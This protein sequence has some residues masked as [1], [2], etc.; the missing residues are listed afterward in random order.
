MCLCECHF[1]LLHLAFGFLLFHVEDTSLWIV[2]LSFVKIY[3]P[4]VFWNSRWHSQL[5]WEVLVFCLF[6]LLCTQL[7]PLSS[8]TILTGLPSEF[9]VPWTP[10][11]L[12][13]LVRV[14]HGG[15]VALRDAAGGGAG[16]PLIRPISLI[17][18]DFLAP[19]PVGDSVFQPPFTRR[20]N[21]LPVTDF[22]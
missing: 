4:C 21:A 19:A 5:E 15:A 12:Y 13:C 10:S 20:E 22:R 18:S 6:S 1:R 17:G 8:L 3:M 2:D 16:S 14:T 11:S 7:L 9:C